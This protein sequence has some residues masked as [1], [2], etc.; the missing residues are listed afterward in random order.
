MLQAQDWLSFKA[1]LPKEQVWRLE[2]AEEE[3][4]YQS[5]PTKRGCAGNYPYQCQHKQTPTYVCAAWLGPGSFVRHLNRSGFSLEIP[6]VRKERARVFS[7]REL[8]VC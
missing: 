1:V 8:P 5:R 3:S 6:Q 2:E 4:R 7:S